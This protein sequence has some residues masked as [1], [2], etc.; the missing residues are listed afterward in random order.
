V[1][2]WVDSVSYGSYIKSSLP[3]GLLLSDLDAKIKSNEKHVYLSRRTSVAFPE[4]TAF[5]RNASKYCG[6]TCTV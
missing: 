5:V 1:I 6:I 4:A 3:E 2:N